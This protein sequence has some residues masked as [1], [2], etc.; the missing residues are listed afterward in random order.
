MAIKLE[1]TLPIF[2]EHG[3]SIRKEFSDLDE[4]QVKI[5]AQ[6]AKKDNYKKRESSSGTNEQCYF[7]AVKR[8]VFNK[9][10]RTSFNAFT[11]PRN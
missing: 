5:V 7:N 10:I 8:R 11:K 6:C 1:T 3:I 4:N 9:P 2:K